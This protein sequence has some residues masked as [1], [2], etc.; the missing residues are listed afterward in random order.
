VETG[1]QCDD[2]NT[3][4]GDGC[5]ATCTWENLC[6]AD[7]AI[8]CGQ[9]LYGTMGTLDRINGYNCTPDSYPNGDVIASFTATANQTVTAQI[10]IDWVLD[11]YDLMVLEGACNPNLCVAVANAVGTFET[12]TFPVQAGLTYYIVT[13]VWDFDWLFSLGW[14]DLTVTCM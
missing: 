3:A 14:F 5:S 9:T 12:V 1:E 11:D 2:G 8:V 6:V 10:V 13:E 7:G 4:G